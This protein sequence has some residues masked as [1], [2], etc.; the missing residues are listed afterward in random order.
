MVHV[1][2]ND[3]GMVTAELAMLIPFGLAFCFLLLWIVS[4][5]MT[6]VRLVDAS[7]EAARMLARGDPPAEVK[8]AALEHAPA[9]S[10]LRFTTTGGFITVTATAK[11][12]MALPMFKHVGSVTLKAL[13]VSADEEQSGEE[14]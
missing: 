8:R 4:L 13:S 3:R 2:R 1:R 12:R 9:G 14:Q 11:S 7:R 10:A 6:Q 5:G